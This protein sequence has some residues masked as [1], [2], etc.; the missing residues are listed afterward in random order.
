MP[1]AFRSPRRAVRRLVACL[2]AGALATSVAQAATGVT[3]AETDAAFAA[4]LV[5]VQTS[6]AADKDRL[7]A[8][9][10]DLTEHAGPTYVE[11]VLHTAA[12]R[13]RLTRNGFTWTVRIPDIGKRQLEIN[14]ID[15][16]YAAATA[17]SPLPSGRDTYRTLN[18][19][20]RD[21]AALAADH[22]KLVKSITLNHP[23]LEG[24]DVKGV[25]ISDNVA[26]TTDGKPV[27]LMLGVH[28]AR[29]WPSGEL[30]MEFA[31]DLVKNFGSDSR[32]TGLL[33]KTRVIV[34][35]VVNVDGFHQSRTWGDLV[36]TREVDNGG[37]VTVLAN[38]GNAYKRKNCR[39]VDGTTPPPDQCYAPYNRYLGVD[40]NRNY[41]GLWGGA[42]AGTSP[43]DETYRGAGPFSEPETQNIRELVSSRHVTTLITNHTFSNLVLRPPGVRKTGETVDEA[44]M[45]DLGGRMAAQNGYQNLH[46]YELYDTTGT[47]EDWSYGATGGFGYTFE[48]GPDEFHP[49][50]SETVAEY[51]GAGDHAGKG[52][53]EAFLIA[54][55]N[56]ANSQTHSLVSGKAPAGAVL[57]L[58]K[59]F[60]TKTS[61]EEQPG[62]PKVILDTLESTLVVPGGGK[63]TWHVNPSTRP[64]VMQHRLKVLDQDPSREES[65]TVTTAGWQPQNKVQ[66]EFTVTEQG[67]GALKVNLD[68]PTPDDVDLNVYLKQADGTLKQVGSSGNFINEKEEALIDNPAPGTYVMEAVNFASVTSE[69]TFKAGLYGTDEQVFGD[70]LVESYTLTCEKPDGAVLQKTTITVDRGKTQRLDLTECTKAFRP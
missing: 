35:P 51:V 26:S 67:I 46:G 25:E 21:M 24:R 7:G 49:P 36:D 42:G 33:K 16:A 52:N 55:E 37:T 45:K 13:D 59:Q 23:S 58:K 68:W 70:G 60:A 10:L 63:Y 28:H 4:Q 20:N 56:A 62:R 39:L 66:R 18:D 1:S 69:V 61:Q 3:A 54:L 40:V 30:S 50:F 65:T 5:R 43:A 38:P 53:R 31:V 27:F 6:T 32:I 34:V 64:E 57:R 44:A 22:P 15:K 29:E 19:Y 12:D 2:A 17:A 8:L 47:T 41:G 9:G 48:I 11:A 14:K